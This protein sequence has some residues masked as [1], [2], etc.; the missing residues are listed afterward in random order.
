VP[1][2]ATAGGAETLLVTNARTHRLDVA[3][4]GPLLIN[5]GQ[6]G[7]YRTLY[8]DKDAQAL[9][10][11]FPTLAPVD[12][13][14]VLSDGIELSRSGYQPMSRGL[15]LLAA[16]QTGSHPK[17]V[18]RAAGEWRELHD[19]MVGDAAAQAKI[20]TRILQ[21]FG[22]RLQQ[23][24]LRTRSGEPALGA[25]LRTSLIGTLGALG[26]PAV[27]A[28]AN[29][30]FAAFQTNPQA[31]EGPLKETWL[32]VI[33]RNATPA[34]WDAL[35]A[36][37]RRTG[38]TVER[39]TLYNLLGAANDDAL[40]RR[41][42]A[43]A[44]SKEPG[45]TVSAS[46]ISA[47]AANKPDLALD[48]V[49]ANLAQVTPLIDR[50]ASSRYVAGLAAGSGEIATIAK[51]NAYAAANLGA[52]DR[53]PIERSVAR[54]RWTAENRPRIRTETAAWVSKL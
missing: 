44:I 10:A 12:Q 32:R 13:F 17:L 5:R 24:G 54:I 49:I 51:L 52:G 47:V 33:A 29:R 7:Y 2:R 18:T 11:A 43:L 15:D 8:S 45:A 48:F 25:L 31:I 28:E 26:D 39:T 41:A 6:S 19:E 21:T 50:S 53:K 37:A 35:H 27:L 9:R 16:V 46:M 4:C 34:N 42:L 20:R 3:G 36:I 30:L 23:L 22:P 1:V 14:G 38:G 40:A